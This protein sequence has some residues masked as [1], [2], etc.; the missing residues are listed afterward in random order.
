MEHLQPKRRVPLILI[1]G[2]SF[3][4]PSV[5]RTSVTLQCRLRRSVRHVNMT[6][7]ETVSICTLS[8]ISLKVK[9]KKRTKTFY[10]PV[11]MKLYVWKMYMLTNLW[12][13]I[14]CKAQ[15][16]KLQYFWF[17]KHIR[18]TSNPWPCIAAGV[19]AAAACVGLCGHV[20]TCR[21]RQEVLRRVS[22]RLLRQ[23]TSTLLL[24]LLTSRLCAGQK[25][26]LHRFHSS[27][28]RN[29]LPFSPCLNALK[30]PNGRSDY[31]TPTLVTAL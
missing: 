6:L 30:Q 14:L 23:F 11:N 31:Q 16:L 26:A 25:V 27:L 28:H 13:N 21:E 1:K 19:Q 5:R 9:K 20:M 8:G 18:R 4:L 3:T 7:V 29:S 24:L 22:P 12:Q 15:Y 2:S 10:C 17:L